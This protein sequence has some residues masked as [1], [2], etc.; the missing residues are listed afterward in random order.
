MR[1]RVT[2]GYE[3]KNGRISIEETQGRIVL[4]I[5][6]MYLSGCSLQKIVLAL[7]HDGIPSPWGSLWGHI[8]VGK[9]L[10]NEQYTGIPPYPPLLPSEAFRQTQIQ[11]QEIRERTGKNS[12]AERE[13]L[14][15][16]GMVFCGECGRKYWRINYQKRIAWP[17]GLHIQG[18]RDKSGNVCGNKRWLTDTEI[19]KAFILLQNRIFDGA[20]T[21][22]QTLKRS[23]RRLEVLKAKY[24]EMLAGAGN[25]EEKSLADIILWIAA[26]EYAQTAG[27]EDK[28]IIQTVEAA[29]RASGF[30]ADVF[31]KIVRK[32][33]V[34]ETELNFELINGQKIR[35]I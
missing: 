7:N 5:F 2:Y 16:E 4:R 26:E 10:E 21:I 22:S 11:R 8:A 12:W 30:Q 24:R 35:S 29:G 9:I 18:K 15:Y 34:T 33:I 3:M 19:E 31:L 17:C 14:P 27:M 32:I 20:V 13:R 6:E 28:T 1:N 23:S 25:Y